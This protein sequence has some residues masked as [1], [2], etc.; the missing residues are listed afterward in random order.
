MENKIVCETKTKDNVFVHI[1]IAVQQEV[2]KEKAF[3]AFYKMSDPSMQI[4]SFVSDVVRSHAPGETLDDLFVEKEKIALDVKSRLTD[5]MNAYGYNIINVLVTD[6][7]PAK[8]VKDAMNEIN[9]NQR[10]LEAAR[11]KA[12]ANKIVVVK[13]AQAEAESKFLQGQGIARSRTAIVSGLRTAVA[14]EGHEGSL[15]PKQ[16]TELLLATQYLDTMERVAQNPATTIFVPSTA[17]DMASQI[18]AGVLQANAS[19]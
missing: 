7:V 3:E 8:E 12:E 11:E 1:H 2:R 13:A 16:I 19:K 10:L 5:V 4:E 17:G 9:T 15:N 18:R 6:I 14:G